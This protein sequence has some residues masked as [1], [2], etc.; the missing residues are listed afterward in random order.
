MLWSTK[1][2]LWGRDCSSSILRSFSVRNTFTSGD[3]YLPFSSDYYLQYASCFICSSLLL[4]YC[5]LL[6]KIHSLQFKRRSLL[7]KCCHHSMRPRDS[8]SIQ[9]INNF[10]NFYMVAKV[11]HWNLFYNHGKWEKGSRYV[12]KPHFRMNW[13]C[14]HFCENENCNISKLLLKKAKIFVY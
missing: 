3:P 9:N 8:L 1:S 14:C 12:P 5:S 2:F 7:R 11:I 6:L 10:D 13:K 4:L